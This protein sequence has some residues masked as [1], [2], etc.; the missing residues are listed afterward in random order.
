MT[1]QTGLDISKV[2]HSFA[3]YTGCLIRNEQ[4]S[5]VK[6]CFTVAG[7]LYRN[8]SNVLRNAIENAFLY[9]LSPF[10]CSKH[11]ALLPLS[12]KHIRI[13]QLQTIAI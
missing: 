2:I 8:G 6:R 5:E 13:Q 7:V 10:L 1:F 4:L 3:D 12:L 9:P 11:V